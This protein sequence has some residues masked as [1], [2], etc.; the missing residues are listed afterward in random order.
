[1][2]DTVRKTIGWVA[3]L[4]GGLLFLVGAWGI[5]A[6]IWGVIDILGEP[7]K[8]WIFWGLAILFIGILALGAG[9][10]L[11]VTGRRVLAKSPPDR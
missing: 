7:D 10:G 3:I 11:I 5:L 8:S 1:M 2:K 4:T 6:Y 9:I